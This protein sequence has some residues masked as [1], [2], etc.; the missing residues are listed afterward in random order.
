MWMSENLTQERGISPEQAR[1]IKKGVTRT[2]ESPVGNGGHS[3][4]TPD[5]A[6]PVKSSAWPTKEAIRHGGGINIDV[7]DRALNNSVIQ[8]RARMKITC[9]LDWYLTKGVITAEMR[10]AG[11]QFGSY[12][13]HSGKVP[14]TTVMYREFTSGGNGIDPYVEKTQALINL[15]DAMTILTPDE[16]D[17]LIEVCGLDNYAGKHRVKWLTTGLRALT[18]HFGYRTS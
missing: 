16:K 7:L 3:N 2:S 11:N 10:D 18:V 12:F 13:F 15:D 8:L 4:A 6:K 14:R 1:A 17:T 5:P 9:K